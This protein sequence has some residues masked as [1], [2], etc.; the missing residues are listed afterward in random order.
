MGKKGEKETMN[1]W[2]SPWKLEGIDR[3]IWKNKEEAEKRRWKEIRGIIREEKRNV[4]IRGQGGLPNK[5]NDSYD[6]TEEES[7]RGYLHQ[8]GCCV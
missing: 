7:K 2:I 8:D 6:H 5:E 3:K 4:K 1:I